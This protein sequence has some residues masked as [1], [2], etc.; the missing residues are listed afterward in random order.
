MNEQ[1]AIDFSKELQQ[2]QTVIKFKAVDFTKE[3]ELEVKNTKVMG[4][5]AGR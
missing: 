2:E 3:F 5:A 4:A 1:Q